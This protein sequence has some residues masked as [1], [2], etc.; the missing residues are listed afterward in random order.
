MYHCECGNELGTT[1]GDVKAT[2]H[3]CL[4]AKPG[5]ERSPSPRIGLP[6]FISRD[7]YE[8]RTRLGMPLVLPAERKLV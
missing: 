5:N 1:I 6:S 4:C 8:E 7:H 2:R 3:P